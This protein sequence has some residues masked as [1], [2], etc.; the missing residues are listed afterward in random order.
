MPSKPTG[1]PRGLHEQLVEID[2]RSAASPLAY[3]VLADAAAT[4]TAV[5]ACL[6]AL[7]EMAAQTDG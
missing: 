3:Y 5:S 1:A 4:D 2:V 6:A 7:H